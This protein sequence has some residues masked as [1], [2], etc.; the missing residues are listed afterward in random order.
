MSSTTQTLVFGPEA[1]NT[2]L[3]SILGRLCPQPFQ[4]HCGEISTTKSPFSAHNPTLRSQRDNPGTQRTSNTYRISPD[5]LKL[6]Y[7]K[8]TSIHNHF[9]LAT[10]SMKFQPHENQ[11][12]KDFRVDTDRYSMAPAR[13]PSTT[14]SK[15][16]NHQLSAYTKSMQSTPKTNSNHRSNL[17]T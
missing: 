7:H 9:G 10:N 13:A 8:N 14:K 12:A 11:Y 6:I 2:K 15:H 17:T 1:T 4:S 3:F 16:K 5:P